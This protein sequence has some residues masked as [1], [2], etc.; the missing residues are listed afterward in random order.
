MG[1]VLIP[2]TQRGLACNGRQMLGSNAFGPLAA[3]AFDVDQA[4]RRPSSKL[5]CAVGSKP[6]DA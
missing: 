3:Q 2:I 5:F 6:S 1:V 4:F